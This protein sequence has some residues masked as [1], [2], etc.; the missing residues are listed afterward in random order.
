MRILTL[1]WLGAALA[2]P[3]AVLAQ[4]RA[5]TASTWNWHG[6]L[7]AGKTLAIRGIVGDIVARP[8][9]GPEAVVRAEKRAHHGADPDDVQIH[10]QKDAEGVT[11]CAVYPN[12]D[13]GPDECPNGDTH[14]RHSHND[15]GDVEVNFTVEVPAGVDFVGETVTGDVQADSMPAN[16]D[17]RSVTGD[18]TISAKGH[19][20]AST[21]TGS[22]F[23]SLGGVDQREGG[24]FKT[25]TGDVQVTLPANVNA[26]VNASTVSGDVTSDFPL[27]I[28]GRFASQKMRG[29]IGSGGPMITFSTVTGDITL[30][31]R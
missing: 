11:V 31:K 16:V 7:A 23:A 3:G 29:R 25:V 4:R 14:R 9:R 6:A 24:E 8:G 17:A 20:S 28:Q 13:A 10:V 26:E 21:V 2:A 15:D 27:T 1:A 19:G 18:V 30:K 22:I 5:G 12:Q